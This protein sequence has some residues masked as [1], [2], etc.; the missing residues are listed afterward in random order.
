MA[1][2]S[3]LI[4]PYPDPAHPLPK[5]ILFG[6]IALALATVALIAGARET[7]IGLTHNPDVPA[8]A[9]RDLAFAD[10]P[11]GSL[12]VFEATGHQEIARV[13]P[14][15]GGFIRAALRGLGRNR[16]QHGDREDAPFRLALDRDNRLWLKDLAT[17]Q[18]IDL[19]AFGPTN[20]DAF[21]AFL[22]PEA[23]SR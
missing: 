1:K 18:L 2:S 14:E 6:G 9:S 16:L 23:G 21:A 22:K 8:V 11:D 10:G 19:R 12:D 3:L 4:D 7:G 17:G 20:A 5:P 13:P 15:T